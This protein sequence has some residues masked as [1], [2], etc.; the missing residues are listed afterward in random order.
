MARRRFR[1]GRSQRRRSTWVGILADQSATNFAANANRDIPLLAI[2]TD[3]HAL[4]LV[5]TLGMFS[6]T[7]QAGAAL[8]IFGYHGLYTAQSGGGGSFRIDADIV[9]DISE[10]N[11]LFWKAVPFLET[12]RQ[13]QDPIRAY[14]WDVKVMRKMNQGDEIRYTGTC[15]NAA[16]ESMIA[17]RMLTLLT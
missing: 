10:E 17:C 12:F 14:D 11:W 16:W 13:P 9:L 7:L 2:A 1:R 3:D 4:T 5:R 15:N 6:L 8:T